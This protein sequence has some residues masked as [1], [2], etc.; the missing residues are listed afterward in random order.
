MS[1]PH[2]SHI[3]NRV[4]PPVPTW[5]PDAMN[6]CKKHSVRASCVRLFCRFRSM[7]TSF[8]IISF[9]LVFLSPPAFCQQSYYTTSTTGDCTVE[10]PENAGYLCDPDTPS[11]ETVAYFRVQSGIYATLDAIAKSLFNTSTSTIASVSSLS[12]NSSLSTGQGL[13]IPMTCTCYGNHS[14]QNVT[15]TIQAGDTFWKLANATY[16]GLTTCQA[17]QDANPQL[18]VRD[19]QINQ[20]TIMPIRC[21]C[22]SAEQKLMGI[23]SLVTYPVADGDNIKSVVNTFGI[24]EQQFLAANRLA[25][26]SVPLF[27]ATTVLLPFL[28][29][30][31]NPP[32]LT[33]PPPTMTSASPS[34][35]SSK[36]GIYVGV[37][38][39]VAALLL[40]AAFLVFFWRRKRKEEGQ[41]P[42]PLSQPQVRPS[43]LPT[44]NAKLPQDLHKGMFEFAS[45]EK[46][47]S[48]TLEEIT[49][50]T[51]N[52]SPETQI[53]G[54]VYRGIIKGRVVA[55]KK[56]TRNVSKELQILKRVHHANLVTLLGSC[57]ASP[58]QSYLVYEYAENGS[59]SDWLHN[60]DLSMGSGSMS[61]LAWIHR[62]QAGLD[63]AT[64]LEY[65]HDHTTPS[66][67]H[68]D[69]K[70]SNILLDSKFRGKLAN[71]ALAKSTTD[72]AVTRHIVGTQGYMAPEYLSEGAVSSKIDVFAFGVVLLEILSGEEAVMR[73]RHGKE[74]FLSMAI[75]DV[76]SDSSD[77]KESLKTWMDPQLQDV[78]PLDCAYSVALLAK[79]CVVDDP[80]ARPQM[81]DVAYTLSKVLEIS[82]EWD[83]SGVMESYTGNR[84]E[85]R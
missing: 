56:V 61:T 48:F 67:V 66:Y 60:G 6:F 82:L 28:V 26:T 42:L 21:A 51:Q 83:S 70:S 85:A 50:A 27:P 30:P 14:S 33:S 54:A 13:Y 71:F 77:G 37:P 43:S 53:K 18:I 23:V 79:S 68:K 31:T 64:A 55:V 9:L 24:V 44:K 22:P 34:S 76:F 32:N 19:L 3:L 39:A 65:I 40:A 38:I 72:M 58:E 29:K 4:S 11:C 8:A 10:H 41:S 74:K 84:L 45:S 25:N 57:I 63:V 35:S 36:T 5:L 49:Q 52:F 7:Y 75:S 62:L 17:I 46:L 47:A 16:E 81:R 20:Q 69:I 1:Y 59:L 78:Y 80:S 73:D 2:L 15:Y 12:T